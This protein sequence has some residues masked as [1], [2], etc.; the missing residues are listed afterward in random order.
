MKVQVRKM[1]IISVKNLYKEY[2]VIE[3]QEGV[4]GS[5]KALVKPEKKI[6]KALNDIN[7]EIHKGESVGYI[8]PNGSGKSTTIKCLI[9][10]LKPTKGKILVDGIDPQRERIRAAK[11]IGV[12]FGQRSNLLWDIRLNESFE[13]NKRIYQISDN[14]YKKNRDELVELLGIH[15]FLNTP[16]RQLSL[17]QRMRG[18][19]VSALLHSPSILFLDEPTVGLDFESRDNILRYIKKINHEKK[20]TVILTSHNI[21]DIESVCERLVVI[22]NGK[23]VEDDKIGN[24]IEKFA[25]YKS[26]V[27]EYEDYVNKPIDID[28]CSITNIQNNV[29]TY[30]VDKREKNVYNVLK[31]I[32]NNYNIKD[33]QVKDTEIEE[34]I[35]KIYTTRV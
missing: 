5:L 13:L 29:I 32:V 11:K 3:K 4:F 31:D 18:E 1:N 14:E 34:V 7:I 21:G 28:N 9:G 12:V 33:I 23:I 6:I 10:I 15:E 25:P 8:G 35:G 19:I 2:V 27:V 20:V 30:R 22:N 26:I 24:V 17:G 16:V